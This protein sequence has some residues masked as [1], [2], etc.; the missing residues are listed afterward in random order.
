M[1]LVR[2]SWAR[3][4]ERHMQRGLIEVAVSIH[5]T[6]LSRPSLYLTKHKIH[7]NR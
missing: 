7:R 5:G 3:Y 6:Y 2:Y 4:I 1:M